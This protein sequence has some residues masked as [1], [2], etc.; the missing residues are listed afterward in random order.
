MTFA[1]KMHARLTFLSVY[2]PVNNVYGLQSTS[3][4]ERNY[5][6]KHL[7]QHTADHP[8]FIPPVANTPCKLFGYDLKATVMKLKAAG[9]QVFVMGDFNADYHDL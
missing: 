4:K 3:A 7:N 1:G 9:H 8:D 6:N 5:I 2:C